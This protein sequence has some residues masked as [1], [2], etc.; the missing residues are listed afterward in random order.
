MPCLLFCF[1]TSLRPGKD[2]QKIID[3]LL[4]ST[5]GVLAGPLQLVF[6][7]S[8]RQGKKLSQEDKKMKF[9]YEAT[10]QCTYEDQ[11]HTF[12]CAFGNELKKGDYIVVDLG[13]EF[14]ISIAKISKRVNEIDALTQRIKPREIIQHANLVKDY[15]MRLENQI[16]LAHLRLELE[17][18]A[19]DVK[20]KEQFRKLALQ[21][22]E[23]AEKFHVYEQLLKSDITSHNHEGESTL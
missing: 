12:L 11:E 22:P 19:K 9:Y 6:F 2:T 23:F 18:K 1:N 8:R 20:A 15:E 14:G 4:S 7:H 5:F 10:Y 13:S 17:E 3:F 21:D 16:K